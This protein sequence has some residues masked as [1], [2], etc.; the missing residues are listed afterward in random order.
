MLLGIQIVGGLFALFMLYLAFLHRKR[1]DFSSKEYILWVILW[2]VAIGVTIFPNVL[3]PFTSVLRLQRNM[4]LIIIA[5][6]IF[7]IGIT[8]NNYIM[9]TKTENKVE[10]L[11][12]NVALEQ[13]ARKGNKKK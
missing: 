8:F 2:L 5:G 7:L 9:L 11:V 1:N 6:F 4:D 12:R 10:K 3:H 13:G